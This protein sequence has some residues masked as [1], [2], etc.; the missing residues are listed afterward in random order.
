MEFQKESWI[1]SDRIIRDC[2]KP[3]MNKNF[4]T[5]KI[6]RNFRSHLLYIILKIGN[7]VHMR[8]FLVQLSRSLAGVA[9][10]AVFKAPSLREVPQINSS[11]TVGSDSSRSRIFGFN[12]LEALSS[13]RLGVI[14]CTIK[15]HLLGHF[16]IQRPVCKEIEEVCAKIS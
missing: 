6:F 9:V 2:K 13:P 10:E 5:R 3:I 1:A 14:G 8:Q 16:N 15:D 11:L 12:F 7:A 4:L